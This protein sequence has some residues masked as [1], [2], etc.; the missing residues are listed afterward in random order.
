MGER[1][2]LFQ[3]RKDLGGL[4]PLE[5]IWVTSSINEFIRFFND[6]Y[7]RTTNFIDMTF[8]VFLFYFRKFLK[9][10]GLTQTETIINDWKHLIEAIFRYGI[11]PLSQPLYNFEFYEKSRPIQ[12]LLSNHW[13]DDDFKD[14]LNHVLPGTELD[15]TVR[16]LIKREITNRFFTVELNGTL[17]FDILRDETLSP[18][19]RKNYIKRVFGLMVKIPVELN[20]TLIVRNPSSH[21]KFDEVECS[22]CLNPLTN[23]EVIELKCGHRLHLNCAKLWKDMKNS[24]ECPKCKQTGVM[25]GNSSCL[26]KTTK[27]YLSRNSPPFSAQNCPDMIK[28]GNDG[29]KYVSV[30]DKNGIYR[31]KLS[32]MVHVKTTSPKRLKFSELKVG[33]TY[34]VAFMGGFGSGQIF[35]EEDGIFK[36]DGFYE[37]I[38]IVEKNSKTAKT[39]DGWVIWKYEGDSI[40]VFLSKGDAVVSNA[41]FP[42]VTRQSVNMWKRKPGMKKLISGT[43]RN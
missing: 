42:M 34:D 29:K 41:A 9:F 18:E 27:K 24:G 43:I 4:S 8:P 19:I 6:K 23:E 10:K 3:E 32:K 40:P 16:E 30:S 31:W 7:A 35:K 20:E 14:I 1:F 5:F 21:S 12:E 33:K 15:E 26:K 36:L 2:W 17:L 39:D 37:T 22:I 25:F 38:K 13:T 11:V 28:T